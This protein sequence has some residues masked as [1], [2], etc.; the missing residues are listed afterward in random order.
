MTGEAIL[1]VEDEGL[2]AFHMTVLLESAGYRVIGQEYSGEMVLK[3][4][5]KS[6][7]PDLILMDIGLA[8]SIDGIETALQI[9]QHHDIPIIF[10][11]AYSNIT[12]IEK[13]KS[14]SSCG[15]ISKPY[16]EKDLLAAVENALRR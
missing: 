3:T 9:R 6:P 7:P 12:K 13:A 14:L 2:I 15:Y 1:V 5:K 4:L 11:T 16:M 10:L 8:G